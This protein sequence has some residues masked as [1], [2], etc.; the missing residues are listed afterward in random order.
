MKW[1][2]VLSPLHFPTYLHSCIYNRLLCWS[3]FQSLSWF[4]SLLSLEKLELRFLYLGIRSKG[5][6]LSNVPLHWPRDKF[7]DGLLLW[8]SIRKKISSST[9]VFVYIFIL[10]ANYSHGLRCH[11]VMREEEALGSVCRWQDTYIEAVRG[12]QTEVRGKSTW[13][14]DKQIKCVDYLCSAA[15]LQRALFV[16]H[17]CFL[18]RAVCLY[19]CMFFIHSYLLF[20][21]LSLQYVLSWYLVLWVGLPFLLPLLLLLLHLSSIFFVALSIYLSQ[22]YMCVLHYLLLIPFFP[23]GV[24][25]VIALRIFFLSSWCQSIS[26]SLY[27]YYMCVFLVL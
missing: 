23:I 27:L 20:V 22:A 24:R 9:F 17:L 7:R 16:S 6:Y 8:L 14:N 25:K 11:Q 13:I 12:E 5:L 15:S 21:F 26:L 19:V 2:A 10:V 18:F 1:S 4:R 3:N